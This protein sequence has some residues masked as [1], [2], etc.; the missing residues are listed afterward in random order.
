[1][2]LADGSWKCTGVWAGD[3]YEQ[4]S[5]VS[6]VM[7]KYKHAIK[8]FDS[9][10]FDCVSPVYADKRPNGGRVFSCHFAG[11]YKARIPDFIAGNGRVR[12]VQIGGEVDAGL[13]T[14]RGLALAVAGVLIGAVAIWCFTKKESRSPAAA[15]LSYM[16]GL[17]KSALP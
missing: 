9:D 15:A 8:I 11:K 7:P 13:L 5:F 16:S 10:K 6:S 12:P 14:S 3:D 17:V 4:G 2:P 1:M